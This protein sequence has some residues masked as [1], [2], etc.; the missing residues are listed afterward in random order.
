[1]TPTCEKSLDI[2]VVN[3]YHAQDNHFLHKTTILQKRKQRDVINVAVAGKIGEI[4]KSVTRVLL[5]ISCITI[6]ILA[7]ITVYDVIMRAIFNN[8]NS[9]VS[10]WGQILLMVSMTCLGYTFADGRSISVGV[11]V[12]RFPKKINIAFEIIMGVLSFVF[13]ILVGWQLIKYIDTA[14]K[15]NRAYFV[16]KVPFWPMYL[17]LGVSFFGAALGTIS[18]VVDRIVNFKDPKDKDIFEENPDLAI[19][20]HAEQIDNNETGGDLS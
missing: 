5:V 19:L 9:G 1:M 14:I 10:E 8:P 18:Y 11:L 12:D 3:G 13:F 20:V 2:I 16:I 7:A 15:F 6:L 4:L 17:A